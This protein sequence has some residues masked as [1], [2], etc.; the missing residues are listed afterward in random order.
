MMQKAAPEM[1]DN[2]YNKPPEPFIGPAHDIQAD[3]S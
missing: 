3:N 2:S 1:K